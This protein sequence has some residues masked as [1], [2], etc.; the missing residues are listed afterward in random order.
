[1]VAGL[2]MGGVL[3]VSLG[4]AHDDL[5]GLVCINTPIE[6]PPDMAPG[7][8]A[9]IEGGMDTMDSIGGDIADPSA[10]E[11]SYDATPLRAL[12]SMLR[13]GDRDPVPAA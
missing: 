4:I 7:I 13:R 12:H 1:V 8:D 9:L 5:A 3:T 6:L 11:A 2:S 10:D